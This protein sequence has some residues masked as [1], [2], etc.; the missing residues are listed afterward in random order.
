[1]RFSSQQIKQ[2]CSLVFHDEKRAVFRSKGARKRTFTF[3]EVKDGYCPASLQVMVE[4][5]V[6][7]LSKLVAAGTSVVVDGY[8]KILPEGKGMKHKT[9]L[10]VEKVI[11]VGTVDKDYPI[12]KKN[13]SLTYL[14][15]YPHLRATTNLVKLPVSSQ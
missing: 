14:R 2:R 3:L 9:E 12:D 1:M 15:D 6:Y 10:S 4:A 7:D 11:S 5:S 8:L 13:L